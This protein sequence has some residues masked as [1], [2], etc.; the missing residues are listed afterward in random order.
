MTQA[1]ITQHLQT[2]GVG[3]DASPEVVRKAWRAAIKKSHPD[4]TGD[5]NHDQMV[6]INLAYDALKEGVPAAKK[7][8]QP[9]PASKPQS[10]R[11]ARTSS[12]RQTLRRVMINISEDMQERWLEE[13]NTLLTECGVGRSS[14]GV[15]RRF[16]GKKPKHQVAIPKAIDTNN[17]RINLILNCARLKSGETYIVI[18]ILTPKDGDLV[19]TGKTKVMVIEAEKSTRLHMVRAAKFDKVLMPGYTG[20]EVY[21][22]T[23]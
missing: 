18:P 23:S 13:T 9:H 1:D 3:H 4:L 21:L 11:P 15:I 8:M 5:H 19:Y 17:G 6:R 22:S 20:Q 7:K 16:L 12:T 2:L 14:V 10:Y